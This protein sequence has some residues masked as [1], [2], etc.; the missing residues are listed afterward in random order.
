MTSELIV[1]SL[2][3]VVYTAIAGLLTVGGIAAEYASFQHLGAGDAMVAVWL[4]AI[5]CVMLYAGAY[6]LGYQKVLSRVV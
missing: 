5:G 4:A 3:L 2:S 1:E 6:G